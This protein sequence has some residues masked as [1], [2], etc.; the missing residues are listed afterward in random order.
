MKK[1]LI[2]FTIGC[3]VMIATGRPE[4]KVYARTQLEKA[5]NKTETAIENAT[6]GK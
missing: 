1:L 3:I 5:I 4:V 6:N 2:G